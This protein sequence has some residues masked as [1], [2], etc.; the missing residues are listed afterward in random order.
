MIK[1]GHVNKR[2]SD[3]LLII[4]LVLPVIFI[5]LQHTVDWGGDYAMYISEAMNIAHCQPVSNIQYVYNT[6]APMIGP[7]LYPVGFPLLLAPV[8]LIYGNNI[9]SMI[10]YLSLI[11]ILLAL[12]LQLFFRQYFSKTV[13]IL[14]VL[15]VLF[16]PWL[17]HFKNE[18]LADVPFTLFFY[19]TLILYLRK[20]KSLFTGFLMGFTILIK[21]AG[22]VLPVAF[23]LYLFY[24][25]FAEPT[26][27][28][29]I[30]KRLLVPIVYSLLLVFFV[31]KILF[32]LPSGIDLYS[33]N[34][35]LIALKHHFLTNIAL[36]IEIFQSFFYRNLYDW[37]FL[38]LITQ[39]VLFTF[40]LIGFLNSKK[41]LLFFVFSVYLLMLIIYPYHSSG[42]RFLLPV[43]P[44]LLNYSVNGFKSI[45]WRFSVRKQLLIPLLAVFLLGQYIPEIIRLVQK[46]EITKPG[47][48]EQTSQEAFEYI[49]SHLSEDETVLFT[50]PRVLALYTGRKS[51]CNELSDD[52]E[53]IGRL[54][55]Q[56][57]VGY[58]LTNENLPN[59]AMEK[60][61]IAKKNQVL[62][63]W[64]NKKFRLYH[65]NYQE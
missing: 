2:N 21:T 26:G 57:D 8:C 36:Y 32:H 61:L 17:L 49:R 43:L 29:I 30:T 6:N 62:L 54:L 10:V 38:V 52:I 59:P 42:F 13:S 45:R 51:V 12:V 24:R 23:I 63:I 22:F 18:I 20:S 19:L 48:Q 34:F 60:Y 58:I 55:K 53:K 5:N 4:L 39:P 64:S 15:V 31:N 44:I 28:K 35:S 14:L 37:K 47:P 65:L 25:L 46:P 3:L 16:N 7:L 33:G 27:R 56:K 50:K 41:D 9:V 40:A 11:L 1:L